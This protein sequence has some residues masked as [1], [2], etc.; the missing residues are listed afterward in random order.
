MSDF[1]LL[2]A[3]E[4]GVTPRTVRR[5][6]H[7]GKIPGAYRTKGGHWRLR[8]TH[9]RLKCTYKI[10]CFVLRYT[11]PDGYSPPFEFNEIAIAMALGKAAVRKLTN[12]AGSSGDALRAIRQLEIAKMLLEKHIAEEMEELTA[13]PVF[14]DALEFSNVAKG[15]ADGE[16]PANPRNFAEWKEFEERAPEKFEYY[17]KTPL[18]DQ[19]HPRAYEALARPGGKLILKSQKLR[20]NG[21]NVTPA[22]LARELCISVAT[23][24]RRY[25][26]SLIRKA[27]ARQAVPPEQSAAAFYQA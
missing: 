22:A 2:L 26:L 14:N 3:K 20:L 19:I 21:C 17:I 1:P 5:W 11:S 8:R 10:A 7:Q 13:M 12:P 16:L 23:L 27:C 15:L 18:L 6:C 4:M 9:G 25:G 24:Y